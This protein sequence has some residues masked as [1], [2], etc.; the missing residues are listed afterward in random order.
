MHFPILLHD[1]WG[2]PAGTLH[3]LITGDHNFFFYNPHEWPTHCMY[4]GWFKIWRCI[5]H[6]HKDHV[7]WWKWSFNSNATLWRP[8]KCNVNLQ[9][10]LDVALRVLVD[11]RFAR[12]TFIRWFVWGN[13]CCIQSGKEYFVCG[14]NRRNLIDDLQEVLGRI[15]VDKFLG[16]MC[17][18][19]SPLRSVPFSISA[20][21]TFRGDW[22]MI[23]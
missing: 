7:P 15:H 16:H 13:H 10:F 14:G 23:V 6:M 5:P 8:E 1:E 11:I 2:E 18:S 20:F 3:I 9:V 22:D 12:R 4:N 19:I 17:Y 21:F